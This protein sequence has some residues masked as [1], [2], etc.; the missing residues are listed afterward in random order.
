MKIIGV[1][2]FVLMLFRFSFYLGILIALSSIASCQK[3]TDNA[4]NFY[5]RQ[6][7][8]DSPE[9][10][11]A[12]NDALVNVPCA[13]DFKKSFPLSRESFTSFT[14]KRRPPTLICMAGCSVSPQ[15]AH[16]LR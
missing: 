7:L 6:K 11:K 3:A 9:Y 2:T 4:M 13:R 16:R 12:L 14:S 1:H 10:S 8:K 5:A 15:M